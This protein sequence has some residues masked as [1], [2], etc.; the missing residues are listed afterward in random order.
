MRFKC[1]AGSVSIEAT[2]SLTAF[3]FA[4]ITILTMVN[5][6]FVQAKM[7]VAIHSAA[8]EISQYSYIYSLTGFNEST[9]EL[10]KGAAGTKKDVSEGIKNVNTVFN[11]IQKIGKTAKSTDITDPD[12]VMKSWDEI[13]KSI[14]NGTSSAQ[15]VEK[16]ISEMAS[17][18]K[19]LIIGMAKLLASEGLEVAKSKLIAA[20]ISKQLV[21]KHLKSSKGDNAERFLK[22]LQVVP[23]ANGSY[24]DG[25]DFGDSTLF[26]YGSNEIR[27]VV[28]YKVRI[29]PLL[30]IKKEFSFTQTAVTHG[31]LGGS[32]TYKS[33]EDSLKK[34]PVNANT[35]W[36][37]ATIAERADLIRNMGIRELKDEGYL[38]TKGLT[39]VQVYNPEKND[40]VMISS[41]NPLYSTTS[42]PIK[43]E[44]LDEAIL[45]KSLYNLVGKILSTTSGLKQVKVSKGSGTETLNCY[46]ATNTVVLVIPED[47]GLKEK[48]EGVIKKMDTKGV[49][50]DVVASYG[51]GSRV[52]TNN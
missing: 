25:L 11:E 51:V 18:P 52:E 36:T 38:Q 43:V 10:A 33:T 28:R 50:F 45:E 16:K 2:I 20:P 23:A 14:D 42:E 48:I 39:D 17:D 24:I 47:P 21:K 49:K 22:N 13:S 9:A 44:D 30:P 31:W 32:L 5:I 1:N 7:A 29:I 27:I 12:A 19:Q 40:F 4:I 34:K 8:K 35:I 3:I 15:E 26:P 41:M 6:C 37:T 46:G